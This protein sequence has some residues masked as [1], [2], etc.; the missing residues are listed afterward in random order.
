MSEH[1]LTT[2]Q[3]EEIEDALLD[4][5]RE[6]EDAVSSF[7]CG[8]ADFEGAV[9]RIVAVV[10]EA[11]REGQAEAW[12]EGYGDCWTFHQSHGLSGRDTN[13]YRNGADQ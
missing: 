12:D 3:R 8:E 2:A 10:A 13:P 4:Y 7:R 9:D 1:V 5:G 6:R 11:R